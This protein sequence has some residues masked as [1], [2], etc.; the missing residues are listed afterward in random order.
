M[1]SMILVHVSVSYDKSIVTQIMNSN[2]KTA[3]L[4]YNYTYALH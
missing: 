2:S 4:N 3:K 1:N